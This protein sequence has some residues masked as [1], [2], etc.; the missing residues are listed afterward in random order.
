MPSETQDLFL[1]WRECKKKEKNKY[2]CKKI[3]KL[4]QKSITK[5][6]Y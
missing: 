2:K 3:Y 1:K 4:Y 6:I 5:I